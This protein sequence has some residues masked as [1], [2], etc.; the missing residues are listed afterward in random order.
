MAKLEN[1]KRIGI[2][3]GTFNPIHLGHIGLARQAKNIL[4]LD[5]VIFMPA[6]V[7]PHKQV[8]NNI[9]AEDRFN[10][11]RLAI[12]NEKDFGVSRLE[13]DLKQKS[14]SINTLK[15]LKTSYPDSKIFFIVGSDALNELHNWKMVDE[16][17]KLT[18]FTVANRP[19]YEIKD[20]PKDILTINIKPVDISSTEIRRRIKNNE[21]IKGLVADSVI[22]YIDKKGLYKSG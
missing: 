3:G 20:I 2:L 10:M 15:K 19:G 18:N 17:L 5:K 16:I 9:D 1:K 14:Y 6:Y 12:K 8:C 4:G 11:V 13:I 21:S 7:P 22:G